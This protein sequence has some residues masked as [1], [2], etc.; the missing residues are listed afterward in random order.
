MIAKS[1][2][3]QKTAMAAA[4]AAVF[5][6][7]GTN[8]A[9]LS[10]GRITVQSALGEPL[11]AEIDVPDIN[12]EEANSL[13]A[14]VALPEAFKA[15]GLE[16][17]AAMS[18]LQAT[19]QRRPDG[20]A[21]IRLS[22][23]RAINDPFVD[24][25][26]EASWSSGRIVRDYT[27]LFDPPSLR[28]PAPAAPTSA[29]IPSTSAVS[30][31]AVSAATPGPASKA[32]PV[33]EPRRAPAKATVSP[34]VAKTSVA[35]GAE[36]VTVKSGDT[37]SKI[38]AA[39]KP[40]SVSLDQML[41]A[42]LRANPDA[43]VAGNINRVRA[44]A[45]MNV[46]TAE[47]A[48]ATP[49][50]EATQIIVAQSKDFN[51]FRRK[52]AGSAPSAQ[53]TATDRR[54]S[55]SVQANVEDKKPTT[56]APDKLTLSKG[57]VQGK[58]AEDQLAKERSAKD[59]STRTAEI[60][61]NISDL[62][63]LGAASSAVAPATATPV[64]ATPSVPVT[65][66]TPAASA[67]VA[68]PV[69]ASVAPAATAS[70]AAPAPKPAASA[71]AKRP[72]VVPV[73]TPE[74]S[75]VDE[76]IDNPL[77]PAGA[78]GLVALLAGFGFY[79]MRQRKNATQVDSSFLESRLQPDSFFGASGG[80]SVDTTDSN[81]ATG[82]SMVYS[83]SQLDA[84]DDVDP[85]AEAD[86]YLA[87][88]RDMQAEEIL[89][90]A[91][92][93]NPGRVAIYQKLLDIFGKRRDAKS[94]ERVAAQ[95]FKITGGDGPEW[96]R[97]SELGLSIDPTNP[98]YQPG[99]QP[100][101]ADDTPSRPAPLDYLSTL[102]TGAESPET[103]QAAA[104]SAGASTDLDLDL[105]F[106]LDEEPASV[107]SEASASSNEP[108]VSLQ[109]AAPTATDLDLDFGSTTEAFEAPAVAANSVEFTLPDL[110]IPSSDLSLPSSDN[111]DFKQ[112]A[113]T[114]FGATSPAPLTDS[115]P[116]ETPAGPDLG[117]LEFDLGSLSLDLE[118][119]PEADSTSGPSANEDPLATKLALAEEFSAI[120]DDDGARA[121]I[122][123]VISE[124]T[125]DMKIKAQRALSN[126]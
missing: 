26:I 58:P 45:V 106:S 55:G 19:L 9:A 96:Q 112:Q 38:A 22:S 3:W 10:L 40:S 80:Q 105:D 15:A 107:I 37:A 88:G 13:K 36:Q 110:E 57:A 30:S 100:S 78:V 27:M 64:P 123:E 2:R 71:P 119:P 44:G 54:A 108:T 75:M 84:A 72:V 59:A 65:A 24:M 86:V 42:L 109:A 85:V 95:A 12:A 89:N 70:A 29:Q 56:T 53:V 46:P 69:T 114:S 120:G 126:L 33:A 115:K 117:M 77:V 20:R 79:R 7:W 90:E 11:R 28:Q 116:D 6:L 25:I 102:S 49:A 50:A 103:P 101:Q 104:V 32:A 111:D 66:A 83:P 92:R 124:A 8:A 121:L 74:P 1:H 17:N 73:V 5:G 91:L 16:Y 122:E 62:S 31:K 76:L 67:P 94:F 118:E 4:A 99:G 43:F 93:T 63:K 41:V 125:G 97:M 21:Y 34:A 61:K 48:G 82:S 113:A 35:T 68:P 98:L 14:A 60:S 52:L 51:D 39:N 23:D 18:G 87:Y 47:Q 81:G